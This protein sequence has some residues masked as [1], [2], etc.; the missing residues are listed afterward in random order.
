MER[1]YLD[2]AATTPLSKTA[3]SAML[4]YFT[5]LFGNASSQHNF[6][7][8]AEKAVNASRQT[9][10]ECI[11]A[12]E[13]EIYFTSCGSESDN[14]AVKGTALELKEK[15]RHIITSSVEHPAVYESCKELEKLGF[16]ITYLPVDKEGFVSPEDLENAIREDTILISVMFANNEIGTIE[17]VKELCDIAHSHGILFHTD[18]VQATGAVLYN[19]KELGVD[20]LSMSAH[21]FYGPKGVGVFYK[22]DGLKIGRFLNG[23]EQE[24]AQ[25]AGTTNTPGIVGTAAA[26]KEA[27]DNIEKDSAY[28]SSLRDYF[29]NK[30]MSGLSDVIYNGPENGN[31]RLPNNAS[32]SFKGIEGESLLF[33]LDLAGIAASSGSACSSGSVDPSRTLMAIGLNAGTANGSVRFT[34]GK[35]NTKEEADTAA[36]ELIKTV[37]RLRSM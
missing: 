10:A 28:I 17:P 3:L 27:I 21:K 23:G 36:D 5:E 6:G 20:M 14:W 1:I 29:V 24:R 19:V 37:N 34:F 30:V 2:H 22:R 16:E 35:N 31:N 7:R 8:E 18:A 13:S 4:P 25:R 33:S 12:K 26:L 32:F 15:G 11:G 9:I